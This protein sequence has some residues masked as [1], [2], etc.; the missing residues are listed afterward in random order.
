MVRM[1]SYYASDDILKPLRKQISDTEEVQLFFRTSVNG[2][3]FCINRGYDHIVLVHYRQVTEVCV[4][5]C[6]IALVFPC[7]ILKRINQKM[8]S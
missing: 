6:L 2:F 1:T 5:L 4:S 8:P 7:S 3:P